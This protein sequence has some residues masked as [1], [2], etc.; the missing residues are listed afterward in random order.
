MRYKIHQII[1]TKIQDNKNQ[2]TSPEKDKNIQES[3]QGSKIG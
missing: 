3:A 2:I 1:Q